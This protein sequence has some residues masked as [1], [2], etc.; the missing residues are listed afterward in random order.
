MLRSLRG[1]AAY[2]TKGSEP[3]LLIGRWG[4]S[5]VKSKAMTCADRVTARHGYSHSGWGSA[6][7]DSRKSKDLCRGKFLLFYMNNIAE[8]KRLKFECGAQICDG[9]S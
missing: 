2:L 1:A 8:I 9:N 3:R 6:S 4:T 7:R 5:C